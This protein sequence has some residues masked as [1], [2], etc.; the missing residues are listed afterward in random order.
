LAP[1]S[2]AIR[3]KGAEDQI[4]AF[5]GPK[6]YIFGVSKLLKKIT[7]EGLDIRMLPLHFETC[8]SKD[9]KDFEANIFLGR[10]WRVSNKTVI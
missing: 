3:S 2:N 10:S 8:E 7:L 1:A 6:R 4:I 9:G 5:L